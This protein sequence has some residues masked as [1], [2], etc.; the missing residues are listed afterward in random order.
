MK[1]R[2]NEH[3]RAV[4]TFSDRSEVARHVLETDHRID[5]GG[6]E[7]VTKERKFY[8]RIFK[9]AWVTEREG[10]ANKVFHSLDP[11][12]KSLLSPR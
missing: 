10:G 2:M 1:E 7:I 9:E 3:R 4:R 8:K 5:F 11:S 6:A 12:W